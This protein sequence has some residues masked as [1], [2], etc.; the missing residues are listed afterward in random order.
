M[1]TCTHTGMSV[2]NMVCMHIFIMHLWL[3]VH[4]SMLSLN[5]FWT[6]QIWAF[7]HAKMCTYTNTYIHTYIHTCMHTYIQTY[8]HTHMHTHT[9][10]YIRNSV[11]F[12]HCPPHCVDALYVCMYV[13]MFVCYGYLCDCANLQIY[14]Y[15]NSCQKACACVCLYHRGCSSCSHVCMYVWVCV[16][17]C[18]HSYACLQWLEHT[19]THS[20]YMPQHVFMNLCMYECIHAHI[21]THIQMYI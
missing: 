4:I 16:C 14:V 12:K 2:L 6:W 5:L 15:T 11:R 1:Y 13:D 3:Y 7:T 21:H 10:T 19:R 18:M 8:I 9:H 17:V 20:W